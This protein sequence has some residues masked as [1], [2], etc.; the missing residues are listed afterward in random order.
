MKNILVVD[1]N[2]LNLASARKTLSGEYKVIPVMKGE[3]ALSYLEHGECD[4]IL[5]DINM[6]EMDGY[7]VFAEIRKIEKCA[8]I[9]II[10][11]TSDNDAETETKCFE[12]GA[13]DFI[14][15]PFVPY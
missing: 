12:T 4:I 11:L 1:D 5:L 13:V 9:P 2:K 15:K 3:Q 7:E 10:F 8:E 6:P 14:A